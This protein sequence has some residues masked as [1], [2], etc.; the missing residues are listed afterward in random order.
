MP[1]IR[2]NSTARTGLPRQFLIS[3]LALAILA[4]MAQV[5]VASQNPFT[6]AP[7][8][9][10]SSTRDNPHGVGSD[11]TPFERIYQA[12]EI[13]LWK[14]A[15]GLDGALQRLTHNMSGDGFAVIDPTGRKIAFD[16]NRARAAGEIIQLDDLFVME[17]GD[18]D[19]VLQQIPDARQAHLTRGSSPAWSAD[20]HWIAFHASASGNYAA[21][22]FARLDPGAPMRDSDIFRLNVDDCLAHR[23]ECLAK[24]KLGEPGVLPEFIKK[25]TDDHCTDAMV[26][27]NLCPIDEDPDWSPDGTTIVFTRHAGELAGSNNSHAELFAFNLVQGTLTQLTTNTTEE[28][29]P[30]WSPDGKQILYMCRRPTQFQVCVIEQNALGAWIETQLT[31]TGQ[32]LSARWSPD[33]QYIVF[34]RPV[35]NPD[36]LEI[37]RF[38]IFRLTIAPDGLGTRQVRQLTMPPGWNAFPSWKEVRV[39]VPKR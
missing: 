22:N 32:F 27:Q 18:Y 30:E 15:D 10:F 5:K 21:T 2:P 4:S 31:T 26:Q 16:S 29:A 37:V 33:G 8:M 24:A 13:Y 3:V 9:L 20:G 38:Q 39:R 19:D 14:T 1:H 36:P 12:S 35:S 23:D 7:A 25:I 6:L 28:R 11:P 17:I 34:H